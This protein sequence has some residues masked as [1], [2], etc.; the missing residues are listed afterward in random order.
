MFFSLL[1]AIAIWMYVT[2]IE[3]VEAEETF[4][5][6]TV[7]FSGEDVLKESRGLLLTDISSTT[8]SV[9]VRASRSVISR[10]NEE[11]ITATIDLS[12][13]TQSGF[14]TLPV[15]VG[16]PESVDSAAVTLVSTSPRN[17]SFTVDREVRNTIEVRGIFEGTVAEGYVAEDLEITPST[18]AIYG[19]EAEV[20]QVAYAYVVLDR[21]DVDRSITVDM[22]YS[23]MNADGEVLE[24]SNVELEQET[25]LVTL[26]IRATKEVALVVDLV[27]SGGATAENAVV[28]VDPSTITLAGDSEV[29]DSINQISLGTV[30]LSDVDGTFERTYTIPIPNELENLTGVTEAT[31]TITIRGLATKTVTVTNFEC[32]NVTEG[33]E[34]EVFTQNLSVTI[35]AP[36][37]IL[38]DIAD[39]DVW[40]EA[41]LTDIGSTEGEFYV[42]VRI[43]VDGHPE[44]GAVDDYRIYI[45]VRQAE[46]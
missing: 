23:L 41:D 12:S 29:L 36:E 38:A 8:V 43:Y 45:S 26:P 17:I 34:A 16:Y 42:P 31:V 7:T 14:Y 9:R 27:A 24:L 13:I 10:L 2:T 46:D 20:S 40:A 44:A 21:E 39:E 30:D 3:G 28:E 5:N 25:V 18:V 37:E 32:I 11:G 19:P 6:I 33:Y 15:T 22:P 35:R 4:S 1:A